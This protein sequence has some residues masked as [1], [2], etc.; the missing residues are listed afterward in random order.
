[1]TKDEWKEHFTKKFNY[2]YGIASS[3]ERHFNFVWDAIFDI[4]IRIEKL[5]ERVNGDEYQK[6]KEG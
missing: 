3:F 2:T 4:L 6:R 5:E 1:M